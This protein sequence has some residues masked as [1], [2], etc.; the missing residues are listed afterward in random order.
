MEEEEEHFSSAEEDMNK[1]LSNGHV[2]EN[3]DE[4]EESKEEEESYESEVESSSEDERE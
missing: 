3:S 1:E 4:D 2:T